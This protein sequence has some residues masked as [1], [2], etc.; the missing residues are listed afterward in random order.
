MGHRPGPLVKSLRSTATG[1]AVMSGY[2]EPVAAES[3]PW[4]ELAR[5]YVGEADFVALTTYRRS[6]QPVTTTVWVA[7]RGDDLVI[8]TPADSHKVT[9]L[10]RDPRI[11][12]RRCSRRGSIQRGA[13]LLVGTAS[14]ERDPQLVTRTGKAIRDKY[15]LQFGLVTTIERLARRGVPSP[16]VS[17]RLTLEQP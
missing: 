6:G 2:R 8:W 12:L 11:S 5:C 1:Q 4:S 14:V 13:P 10:G 15:G 7:E 17:L 9:R 3:A 16:R